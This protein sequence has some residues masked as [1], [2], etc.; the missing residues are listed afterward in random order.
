M[1]P[2][3]GHTRDGGTGCEKHLLTVYMTLSFR[4]RPCNEG[5]RRTVCPATYKP[6]MHACMGGPVSN[7]ACNTLDSGRTATEAQ[8]REA[9]VSIYAHISTPQGAMQQCSNL[10]L[11]SKSLCLSPTLSF[12][13]GQILE[14]GSCFRPKWPLRPALSYCT[15]A[16]ADGS[17][18]FPWNCFVFMRARSQKEPPA[19]AAAAAC[20]REKGREGE[21][22]RGERRVV[23][24]REW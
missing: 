5:E 14:S 15:M 20:Q 4:T 6:L 24:T 23:I 17:S 10:P 3:T 22:G 18:D 7:Q 11:T 1:P 2:P 9:N 13:R 12:M 21:G 19:C 8:R 16:R